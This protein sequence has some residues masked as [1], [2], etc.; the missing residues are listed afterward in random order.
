M[1]KKKELIFIISVLLICVIGILLIKFS[2]SDAQM[3]KITQ[4][5]EVLYSV[6]LD[7][8]TVIALEHNTVVIKDG[9]A[10]VSK[11]DCHNQICVNTPKISKKGEQIICLPN[12]VIVEVCDEG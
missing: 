4:N 3:V 7:I 11:A 1:I 6:P 5:N 2:K 8:D 10:F 12:K 9:F